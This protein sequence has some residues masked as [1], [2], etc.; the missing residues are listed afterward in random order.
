MEQS[1]TLAIDKDDTTGVPGFFLVRNFLTKDEERELIDVI[2]KE[3]WD[4]NRANTRRVQLY[5]PW[6]E[7]KYKVVE[8]KEIRP[9]PE[10]GR[11]LASRILTL[12]KEHFTQF[13]WEEYKINEDKHTELQVNEYGKDSLLGFH[14]DNPV[15]YREV[16]FGVSLLSDAYLSFE[17]LNEVRKV[18]VPSLSLYLMTG[19]SRFY[20]PIKSLQMEVQM[21]TRNAGESSVRRPE[22]FFHLSFCCLHKTS[23]YRTQ[24]EKEEKEATTTY[25][26]TNGGRE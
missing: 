2:S 20:F 8:K 13:N 7:E 4:S 16:I 21:E 18:L 1:S 17:H 6:E 3:T 10:P 11:I 19:P 5:V 12:C 23:G 9:I 22:N 14:R 26:Q 24:K 25:S 15:A